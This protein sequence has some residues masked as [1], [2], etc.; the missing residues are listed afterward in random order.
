MSFRTKSNGIVYL[1]RSDGKQETSLEKQLDWALSEAH[2][3]GVK[4]DATLEDL[5]HMRASS[6]NAYKSIRLDNA[7]TGADLAR[8]GLRA[9]IEDAANDKSISHIFVFKRDRLGR[10]D[11]PVEMMAVEETLRRKGVTFVRSDGITTPAENESGDISEL[12]L[13]LFDYHRSGQ[14][15]KDLSEQMI[16][17]QLQ[18]AR[19]G[20]W[21]G[22]KP[23]YGFVRVL[24]DEKGN[25]VE[26]LA[27]GKHVRQTGCHVM[28]LPKDE[29]KIAVWIQ[30]LLWKEEGWGIKRIARRLNELKIPSPDAGRTRTDHGVKHEVSGRWTMTTVRAL[31]MN[32]AIIVLLEYGRASEG[33]HRRL[34]PD[35]PRALLDSDRGAD[36]QPKK[37]INDPALMVT[38]KMPFEPCFDTVRWGQ[39]QAE[40][41]RRGQTQR[42][43]PKTRDPARYPL[44]CRVTDLT[45]DCRSIMYGCTVGKRRIYCCGRYMATSGAECENNTVD[46][47]ALLRFILSF[48]VE[49][50]HR[51]GSSEKLR[52]KLMDRA[53]RERG[54][55]PLQAMREGARKA[56]AA[57]VE[58]LDQQT[59]TA[60]RNM[61]IEEDS[62]IR[63]TIR[64]EYI[65]LKS[66]LDEARRQ[67]DAAQLPEVSAATSPEQE[68]ESAMRLLDSIRLVATVD[69]ARAQILPLLERLKLNIGLR[70]TEGL[71]GTKRRVRRL[72]GGIIA[73]GD[74]PFPKQASTPP[75]LSGPGGRSSDER[76]REA[77]S[78]EQI[79]MNKME[80]A[81]SVSPVRLPDAAHFE[82]RH[83]EGVSFTKVSCGD[84]I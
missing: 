13:M 30:I 5:E 49:L 37:R 1:R 22:G 46:G 43:I 27:R 6:L 68:V 39:I 33:K 53:R 24:V 50:T 35:G 2:R 10:P 58:Q 14:F 45:E 59:R 11:S 15:L 84:R 74:N 63:A 55:D 19:K 47:E 38:S 64:D 12:V 21:A 67:L 56:L 83:R 60:Q 62:Q 3:L 25:Q 73:F 31:C 82:T 79:E 75:S 18:L 81:A 8:P 57:Q 32:K 48:L 20:C 17:T 44:S 70:F 16:R 77:A 61:A 76:S 52:A 7:I 40:T 28:L 80:K 78:D 29:A 23:P 65:T 72:A 42:G 26:E 4:V 34:G 36:H 9:L 41:A 54:T 69:S 71:K 66:E 51:H